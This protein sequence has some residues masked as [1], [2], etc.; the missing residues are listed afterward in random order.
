MIGLVLFAAASTSLAVTEPPWRIDRLTPPRV[1][2]S[3]PRTRAD[4]TDLR[5]A[6]KDQ[7]SSSHE[8]VAR[9]DHGLA[10]AGHR[11]EAGLEELDVRLSGMSARF[12]L[13]AAAI[14][15]TIAGLCAWII[16]L[17]RQLDVVS[18]EHAR[19]ARPIRRAAAA[20][21]LAGFG[22][23]TAAQGPAPPR[24]AS[25]V[26]ACRTD[27]TSRLPRG[28]PVVRPAARRRAPVG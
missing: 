9:I 27:A 17:H 20:S 16:R 3:D 23:S 5:A 25:A 10:A 2:S 6:L 13:F 28:G 8:L 12:E 18:R 22:R 19:L 4:I 14:I 21:R 26:A 7:E 1:A 11:F 15:A 24:E